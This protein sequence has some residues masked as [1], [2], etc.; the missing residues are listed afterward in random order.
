MTASPSYRGAAPPARLGVGF[1]YMEA[2]GPELYRSGV[3]DFVEVTPDGFCRSSRRNGAVVLRADPARVEKARETCGG[4]PMVAHGV[5]LSIGSAHGC[6]GAYLDML[7]DFQRA[8]PFMW[9]SE[10]LSFQTYVDGAGGVRETGVPLPLPPTEEAARLVAS[11]AAEIR[12]RYGVPFLLEN[13]AHYLVELSPDRT[14]HQEGALMRR[15]VDQ[16]ACGQLLDLHNL[17]CNAVNFGFDAHEALEALP[18]EAVMELHVAGGSWRDGFY[19]DA[20]DGRPPEAVWDLLV[21]ALSVCPNIGG[22]V[23]EVLDEHIARLSLD[24]IADDL[25]RLRRAWSDAGASRR[26]ATPCR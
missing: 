15:I 14:P 2:L 3:V 24:M 12:R 18:L 7:D 1:S 6:N 13:P 19:T 8:W 16:G 26:P 17:H 5:E 25:S 4:L 11:R 10:H 20:H 22:V 23:F 21:H 9:H